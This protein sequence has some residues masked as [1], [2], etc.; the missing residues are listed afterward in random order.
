MWTQL[1]NIRRSTPTAVKRILEASMIIAT[2]VVTLHA[3]GP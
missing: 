2:V 3:L 1:D